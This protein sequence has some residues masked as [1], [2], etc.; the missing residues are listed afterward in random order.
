MSVNKNILIVDDHRL[1]ADGLDFILKQYSNNLNV[2]TEYSVRRLLNDFGSLKKY[3][4]VLMDLFMPGFNGFDFLRAVN[5]RNAKFKVLIVSGSEEISDVE[6]VMKLGSRGFAPKSLPPTEMV[7]AINR[8]L[9]GEIFLTRELSQAINWSVCSDQQS[10]TKKLSNIDLRPRQIEV[11]TLIQEGHSNNKIGTILGISESAV[12]SHVSNL[13][14]IL[15]VC[16][17]TAAIKA[18]VSLD[19][20]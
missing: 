11:L 3:D 2:R 16:N 20:L 8:V 19:I 15:N 10:F 12:K 7:K 9:A 13:F 6:N 1:F 4:L 17:R 14:K 5:H 18:G